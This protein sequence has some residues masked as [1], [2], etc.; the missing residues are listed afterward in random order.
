[1]KTFARPIRLCAAA[2]AAAGLVALVHAQGLEYVRAHYTK[3]EFRIPMRDGTKLFTAVYVPKDISQTYPIMLTR[4]PYS[5]APYGADNYKTDLGPSEKFGREGF[6]FAYQDV[7][8]RMMSEGDF[9]DMRPYVPDKQGKQSDESSDTYDTID[10]LLKH[11]P[12]NNGRVG[13]YGIS[14]PGFYSSMASIDAHPAL[15]AVSPQA[16]IADW[17]VGDDFHHNGAVFL[18]H[19]FGFFSGFGWPR[20]EP[21]TAAGPHFQFDTPDGYD[22]YM[23]MGTVSGAERYLHG[24]IAFWEDLIAHPNYDDFWKARN[25]LPHLKNIKPAMLTVGGWFDAEDLYGALNTFKTIEKQG[26]APANKLVMGPWSHGGWSRSTGSSLG[27]VQFNSNTS[28]F[29]RENIEFPF[30]MYYLKDKGENS[31]PKAYLFETGRNQWRKLDAWPPKEARPVALYLHAGGKLS[32]DPPDEEAGYDEYVSDPNKPVPLVGNIV[33]G[34]AREY[35]VAD[36]RF[37]AARP[38]VL[39]YRTE[40][41]E[42][43]VTLAGPLTPSL[44]V[45]TSGTDSDFAVKLIDV[46]PND[47][48]PGGYQQLVRGEPFRGRFRNGYDKP[49]AFV[50]N[51]TVKL[52]FVMPDVYHTFRRG[53]RIMVQVQSSWFPLTDRNPQKFVDIS[54]A[55]PEDFQKAIE[56]VFRSKQFPSAVKVPLYN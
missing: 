29:Y 38:D 56:R 19:A 7:R 26:G 51:Q 49:E 33:M 41:L 35:M 2:W 27:D 40:P 37:A 24:E 46:Y 1:M 31:L 34:M 45:S 36:Q 25:V 44:F 47:A 50:P 53:H 22:F 3:Y 32:F 39:V 15:K 8:G 18:A 5:V 48:T 43:D 54:K 6:I 10:W 16:P 23:R 30:F 13:V 4:T 52:E 17:F 42:Q 12:H 21:T 55:K 28:E 9:Q 14:Y 20:P 11:V